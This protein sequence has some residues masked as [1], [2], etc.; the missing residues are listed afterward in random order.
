[1]NKKTFKDID[2]T[3]K[4]VLLRVD[5]NVPMD[6]SFKIIDDTRIMATLPTINYLLHQKAKIIICS[7]LGR[8]KGMFNPKFSLAPVAKRLAEILGMPV[9]FASDAIG[10][11][12][13]KL[14]SEMEDGEIVMLENIRF[15][16]EEEANDDMFARDLAKLADVFVNDAFGTAHRAHASTA[17]VANHIPAVAGFLMGGEIRALSKVTTNPENPF[18]VILGGAKVSDKIG[19]IKQLIDKASVILVGGAMANT[20]IV[21]QGGNIGLGRYEKDKVEVAKNILALAEKK[22]V[23]IVLP[24]DTVVSKEF[25]PDAKSKTVPS[26]VVPE[27]YQGMDIGKRTAKIFKKEIKNAKTI[28]WNGPMGVYEFKKFQAGTKAIAKAVAKSSA[29]SVIGGGDS[30]AAIRELGFADK[31]THLS[32]GGGATLKFLEGSPLPGVDMLEDKE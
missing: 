13:N 6:E 2:V 7:H 4:K 15:Y 27:E 28:V 32:T 30:V 3:G 11:S 14:I 25:A 9:K 29:V 10:E 5:F 22:N 16:P 19:V 1:M 23:K 18:V 12:A 24:V 26:F 21:A 31:V 8:P 20:F 17:G